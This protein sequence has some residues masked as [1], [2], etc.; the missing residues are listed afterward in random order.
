VLPDFVAELTSP[1]DTKSD[2][3]N[4]IL[5]V[6]GVTY[7]K[8]SGVGIILESLN[9]VFIEKSLLFS[10][11]ANNNQIEYKALIVECF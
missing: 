4:W 3:N 10:F 2:E 9:G 5:S 6:D 8:G 1:T 7:L 11:K